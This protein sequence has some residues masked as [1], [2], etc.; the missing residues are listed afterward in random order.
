[1][2]RDGEVNGNGHGKRENVVDMHGDHH[3][4][5]RTTTPPSARRQ[6]ATV[7]IGTSISNDV[8]GSNTIPTGVLSRCRGESWRL[9]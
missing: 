3:I 6:R 8:R 2:A 7:C 1:M 5:M 9:A 4:G